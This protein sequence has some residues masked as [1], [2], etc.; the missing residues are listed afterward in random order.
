MPTAPISELVLDPSNPR[1]DVHTLISPAL[2]AALE[3]APEGEGALAKSLEELGAA[4]DKL[5]H[6]QRECLPPS[7]H[8]L[9]GLCLHLEHAGAAAEQRLHLQG[10]AHCLVLLKGDAARRQVGCRCG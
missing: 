6:G 1:F 2:A 5:D 4:A 9:S 10:R 7:L 8:P 3:A